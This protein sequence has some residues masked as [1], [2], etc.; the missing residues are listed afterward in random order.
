[1]EATTH[2]K[3]KTY[4]AKG[5]REKFL[6]I[7]NPIHELFKTNSDHFF[8]LKIE[9]IMSL[10]FPVPPSKHDCH[11]LIFITSGKHIIKLGF[12]EYQTY[13]NE[14]LVVPAGQVFSIEHINTKHSGYI[15]QF[16]PDVLIGKHGNP[17]MLNDFDFLKISGNPKISFP[18]KD[19]VFIHNILE[20]LEIEYQESDA[21][22]LD[23]IQSYLM[24]LFCEMNRNK[25]KT[26]KV[27]S[28]AAVLSAKFKELIY[29]NIKINHQVNFYASL[30]NVTPNHLN[31]SV[32]STTGKSATKWIDET[33]LLEAK[34]LL[35]Q[36]TLSI[37]EIA[38]MVGHED[39]SYFSRFFKKHEAM[40][41][42]QYRKMIEKS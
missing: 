38:M 30:L 23:L 7:E 34:Y 39:Q 18:A 40:S 5:F 1:M 14:I 24:T 2:E 29:P 41:P 27:G 33:I 12:E 28:A 19:A 10:Q 4:G 9:E 3:I 11:T 31:K 32:K 22:N 17:E 8:C 21:V 35:Y 16:K 36:T 20:R 37:S 42:V 15:C 25:E 26:A 13:P 6:G